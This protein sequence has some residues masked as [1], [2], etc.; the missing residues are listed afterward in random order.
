MEL[1]QLTPNRLMSTPRGWLRSDDGANRV[2]LLALP[3]GER[4][5]DHQ[6]HEH[7]LVVVLEGHT[8]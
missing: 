8:S 5:D 7:T 6:V 4:L 3:K 1:W 2:I